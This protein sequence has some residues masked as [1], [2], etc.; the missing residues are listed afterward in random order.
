MCK[1]VRIKYNVCK[2]HIPQS[3]KIPPA[4]PF[5]VHLGQVRLVLVHS[6]NYHGHTLPLVPSGQVSVSVIMLSLLATYK[7]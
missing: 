4:L 5:I 7:C 1:Y 3:P 2:L 6:I